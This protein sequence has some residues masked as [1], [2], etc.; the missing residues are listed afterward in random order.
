MENKSLI[1]IVV[2]I[3]LVI[4]LFFVFGK[5]P[6]SSTQE[7]QITGVMQELNDGQ[8]SYSNGKLS[9]KGAKKTG[10]HFGSFETVSGSFAVANK[11]I[12]SGEFSV[13]MNSI[14]VEDIAKEDESNKK[15]S[16]HLKSEDF[17]DTAKNPMAKIVVKDWSTDN[18]VSLVTIRG[19]EKEITHPVSVTQNE[20]GTVSVKTT[21]T[22]QNADF[23]VGQT[24]AMKAILT[25]DFT[26]SFDGT[27]GVATQ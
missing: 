12:T 15:L 18:A 19:V 5:S 6:K 23:G 25:G 27:F 1:G 17:F 7:P 2:A 16:D 14:V 13:D 9:W 20:D 22:L 11:K 8:Y 24:V 4:V 21:L 10:E 3:I 26:V